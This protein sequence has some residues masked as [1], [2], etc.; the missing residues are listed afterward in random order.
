[1]IINMN[2][3]HVCRFYTIVQTDGSIDKSWNFF[4]T[5]GIVGFKDVWPFPTIRALRLIFYFAVFEA[6]LQVL[7]PGERYL[8]PSTPAGNRPLYTV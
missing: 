3:S 8:G 1:M 2:S 4:L 7:V 6:A 5:R